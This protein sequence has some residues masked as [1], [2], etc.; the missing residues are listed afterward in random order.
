[1][2]CK[3]PDG[4]PYCEFSVTE[5]Q[6]KISFLSGTMNGY[7]IHMDRKVIPVLKKFLE[8]LEVENSNSL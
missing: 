1:M 5:H 2:I 7:K 8:S 4:T 6:F 3:K